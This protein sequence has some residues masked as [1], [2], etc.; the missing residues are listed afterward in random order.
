MTGSKTPGQNN[1]ASDKFLKK[2]AQAQG[3]GAPNAP[4]HKE[5]H[6]PGEAPV[7]SDSGLTTVGIEGGSTNVPG[8]KGIGG[9]PVREELDGGGNQRV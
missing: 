2:Q 5:G 8:E 6:R 7:A 4:A 9:V 3:L 1:A